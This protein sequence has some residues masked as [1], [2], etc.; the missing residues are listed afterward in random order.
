MTAINKIIMNDF[1]IF[2]KYIKKENEYPY[3]IHDENSIV[4]TLNKIELE[5][6]QLEGVFINSK[7]KHSNKKNN[8]YGGGY[9]VLVI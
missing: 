9:S 6:S 5:Y 3:I 4:K 8:K 7:K 1:N 2:I